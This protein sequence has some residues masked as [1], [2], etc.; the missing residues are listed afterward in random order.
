MRPLPI[1]APLPSTSS[2]ANGLARRTFTMAE[3]ARHDSK[4]DAWFVRDGKVYDAS[5]FMQVGVLHC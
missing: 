3:V 5:P 2:P 4:K 1:Q